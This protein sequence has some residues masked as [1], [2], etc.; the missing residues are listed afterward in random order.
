[1][2]TYPEIRLTR[3]S[4][5]L[6]AC[7]K[8]EAAQNPKPPAVVGFRTGTAGQP[9]AGLTEDECCTGAA[10]VR[11]IRTFPSWSTP[12]PA[13]TSV[14]CAQPFAA[15]FE[16]S[17]WRCSPIGDI[18]EPPVQDAWD[19]LHAD[20]IND[21]LTMMAAICCL[22]KQLDPRSLAY[23]DWVPVDTDGGCVGSRI[24]ITVDLYGGSNA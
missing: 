2:T 23:G 24:S 12:A 19:D 18:S 8:D 11:L 20:L 10:F 17:M 14:S 13:T 5:R 21:R 1:M 22:W 16:L 6:L 15:E 3:M 7:L 9:L 4:N